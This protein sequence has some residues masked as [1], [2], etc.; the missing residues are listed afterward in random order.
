MK[1]RRFFIKVKIW[2]STYDLKNNIYDSN[3]CEKF[4]YYLTHIPDIFTDVK[5]FI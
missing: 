2:K 1:I 5:R 4:I 3:K